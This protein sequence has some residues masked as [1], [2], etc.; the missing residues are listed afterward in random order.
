L[1]NKVE[2]AV[3][4]VSIYFVELLIF[5]I[6]DSGHEVIAQQVTQGK[7]NSS[8]TVSIRRVLTDFQDRIVFQ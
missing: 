3:I 2:D 6:A 1:L 8:I 4:D 7:H 5:K